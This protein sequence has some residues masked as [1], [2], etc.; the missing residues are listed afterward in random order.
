M[1]ITF[2]YFYTLT[3]TACNKKIKD[4]KPTSHTEDKAVFDTGNY[5][6]PHCATMGDVN[7]IKAETKSFS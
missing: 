1:Q 6:C 2:H 5:I 3:C 7:V 4:I